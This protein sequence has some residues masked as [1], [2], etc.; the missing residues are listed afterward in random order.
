MH[1]KHHPDS[2]SATPGAADRT[3]PRDGRL[4][5]VSNR[6]PYSHD[7][8]GDEVTV[9][10]PTGGLT[11]GL[12][13]VLQRTGGTW[14]AWGDGD[15]DEAVVDEDDR[16]SVPPE[17]PTYDIKR[18]WLSDDQVDDYYYGYSNQVLW[19]LCHSAL[20]E[21]RS[22][23]SF[24]DAY[25]RTNEEFADAVL[26]AIESSPDRSDGDPLV[27]FQDYHLGLAPGMVRDRLQQ[28]AVL[29]QFWHIP[30][31]S[32]DTYRCCPHAEA[33]LRGLLGNDVLGFHVQRYRTNFF[34]CVEACLPDATVERRTDEVRY[35]GSVTRVEAAPLGVPFDR[36]HRGATE[37][38]ERE[39][40]AGFRRRHGISPD[41]TLAVG[42]D[43][44]DYTKGIPQRLRAL[45][46]LWETRPSLRGSLTY[47][48]NGSE[49]RSKI[50]AYQRVQDEVEAL[51]SR[52]NDRFGTDDWRPVVFFTDQIP[53][54]ELFALYRHSDVALV[55]PIRD[56]MNLVAKEYV[57]AQVD[58]DGVL[59]LS[60][61]TGAHQELGEHAVT[62]SPHAVDEFADAIE[63][64]LEMPTGQRRRRME[65]LRQH[66]AEW[67]L[68]SW[69]EHQFDLAAT[70]RPLAERPQV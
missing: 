57:A 59:V 69:L 45:E 12:D 2:R 39:F 11:A 66:V 55:S 1:R 68:D 67:D 29:M 31:P 62:V 14:I 24:W 64:A 6:Q 16:V 63:G 56:G 58:G 26:D 20:S 65:E 61:Q 9:D 46:H 52:I 15:A 54:E 44:L 18:V 33:L 70:H 49:S 42:V 32:W 53:Q 28:D 30:W 41:T 47:V 34:E 36:I 40:D 25:R 13:P 22:R 17:D 38:S 3:R 10:R 48:Q 5:V 43:R 8:D 37:T 4:L 35:D 21:I 60:D 7:Y 50:D 23:A 27:W 51:V 19:P